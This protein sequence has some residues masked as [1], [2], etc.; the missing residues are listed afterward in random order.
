MAPGKKKIMKFKMNKDTVKNL[1]DNVSAFNTGSNAVRFL[2]GMS[3]T[4]KGLLCQACLVK[5]GQQEYIGFSTSGV[6]SDW[7]EGKPLA[8]ATKAGLFCDYIGTLLSFDA[9][10]TFDVTEKGIKVSLPGTA[11]INLPLVAESECEAM[12]PNDEG[13]AYIAVCG[14]KSSDFLGLL[15][16][17]G[18]FAEAGE[19]LRAVTNH[20]ALA[21]VN[22]N[23]IAMSA[24]NS[25]VARAMKSAEIK[26]NELINALLFF[27]KDARGA[28]V[29]Q[30]QKGELSQ[31]AYFAE[32]AKKGYMAGVGGATLPYSAVNTLLKISCFGEEIGIKVTEKNLHI[33]SGNLKLCFK[34]GT[35]D[36]RTYANYLTKFENIAWTKA[37]VDR[38]NLMNAFSLAKLACGETVAPVSVD[39]TKT[40]L[41]LKDCAGNKVKVAYVESTDD[42]AGKVVDIGCKV[43]MAAISRFSSGNLVIGCTD[44]VREP[45]FFANGSMNGEGNTFL[46]FV[47]RTKVNKEAEG[48]E[49]KDASK[50]SD[51]KSNAVEDAD[52]AEDIAKMAMDEEEAKE[53]VDVEIDEPEADDADGVAD[54]NIPEEEI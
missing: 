26:Y 7:E 28:V 19:D 14:I 4:G 13:D 8:F 12:I 15:K 51:K 36:W 49:T 23:M 44:N 31:E 25:G 32:A 45:V 46:A 47:V 37:V 40:G 27:E 30:V 24:S 33:A 9:D 53:V 17:G 38:D 16:K 1:K 35:A 20:V 18:Y 43:S 39:C 21:F 41:V 42:F 54:D 52:S 48:S 10:F 5:D 50:K 22:G 29:A 6:P 2:I 3:N 34:L 11:A